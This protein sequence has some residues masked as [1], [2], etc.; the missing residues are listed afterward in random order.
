[1]RAVPELVKPV[2]D[3]NSP[4]VLSPRACKAPPTMACSSEQCSTPR[5]TLNRLPSGTPSHRSAPIGPGA[6]MLRIYSVDELRLLV[7]DIDAPDWDWE[8][9]TIKLGLAPAHATWLIGTPRPA[10]AAT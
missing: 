5:N 10:A 2:F 8:I 1:M 7:A 9:G 4:T 3:G 6:I